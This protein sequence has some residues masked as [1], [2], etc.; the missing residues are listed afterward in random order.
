MKA[1]T[2]SHLD[3]RQRWDTKSFHR[4]AFRRRNINTIRE[5]NS[6][7]GIGVRAF[8]EMAEAGREYFKNIYKD[9]EEANT[10]IS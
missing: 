6:F 8:K 4:L 3:L 1:K 7:Y 9:R 5:I 10:G 2:Q